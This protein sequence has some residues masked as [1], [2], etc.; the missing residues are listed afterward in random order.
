M[1]NICSEI[2]VR[3]DCVMSMKAETARARLDQWKNGKHI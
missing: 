3:K 1:N 2:D